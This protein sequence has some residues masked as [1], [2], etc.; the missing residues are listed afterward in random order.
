MTT[1]VVTKRLPF[2]DSGFPTEARVTTK[3][4]IEPTWLPYC[5]YSYRQLFCICVSGRLR[6]GNHMIGVTS[7]FRKVPFSKCYPSS[8]KRKDCVFKFLRFEE[9]F[10]KASF[11]VD[12]F[13]GLLCTDGRP[14]RRTKRCVFKFLRPGV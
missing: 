5:C 2:Y 7:S 3:G 12:N 1:L 9:R 11:S 13:P 10:R 6:Q 14:N 8:L 4:V